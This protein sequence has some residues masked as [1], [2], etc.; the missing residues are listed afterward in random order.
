MGEIYWSII[1]TP[2]I[3]H[4]IPILFQIWKM[5]SSINKDS[6]AEIYEFED[7][8]FIYD[9]FKEA[10]YADN[11]DF[12]RWIISKIITYQAILKLKKKL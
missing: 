6:S 2:W 3:D 10:K 9:N 1:L 8:D 12:N 11:L 5:I 4:L 7:K